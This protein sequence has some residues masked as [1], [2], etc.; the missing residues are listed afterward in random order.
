MYYIIMYF[1][2]PKSLI[3]TSYIFVA[4]KKNYTS[5]FCIFNQQDFK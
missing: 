3:Y 5:Y 4:F 2:A 1:P